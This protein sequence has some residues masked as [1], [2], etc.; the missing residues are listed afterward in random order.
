MEMA[1]RVTSKSVSIIYL[2]ILVGSRV[3]D[4]VREMEQIDVIFKRGLKNTSEK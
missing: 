1:Y 3:G 4:G 2:G